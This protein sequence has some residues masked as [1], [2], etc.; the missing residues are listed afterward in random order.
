MPEPRR[1]VQSEMVEL[2]EL[3]R[4]AVTALRSAVLQDGGAFGDR[5]WLVLSQVIGRAFELGGAR[6]SYWQA[7]AAQEHEL[8]EQSERKRRE[9]ERELE[10]YRPTP[11]SQPA[12]RRRAWRS[13]TPPPIPREEEGGRTQRDDEITLR[14]DLDDVP[15]AKE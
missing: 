3:L 14:I 4:D 5:S 2:D 7:R 13:A 8:L 9:T 10:S 6:R 12:A 11:P 15:G 1:P